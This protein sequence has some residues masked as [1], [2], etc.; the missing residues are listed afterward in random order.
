MAY[1]KRECLR[2]KGEVVWSWK[3]EGILTIILQQQML[4]PVAELIDP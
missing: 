3:R 4:L 2:R 1:F